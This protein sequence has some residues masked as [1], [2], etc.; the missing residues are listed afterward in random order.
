MQSLVLEVAGLTVEVLVHL[1]LLL[2][3][4]ALDL[5][6]LVLEFPLIPEVVQVSR[7]V[8]LYFQKSR[9]VP[10]VSFVRNSGSGNNF[11]FSV[12]LWFLSFF[13]L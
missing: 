12:P 13:P 7:K 5:D 1:A 11:W 10:L 2:L 9:K 8:P 4:Q 6:H 3:D